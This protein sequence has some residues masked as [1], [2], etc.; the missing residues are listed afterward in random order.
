[1]D[2]T[3]YL[4]LKSRKR[5]TKTKLPRCNIPKD[6]ETFYNRDNISRCTA[7]KHKTRTSGKKDA[8]NVPDRH[9]SKLVQYLQKRRSVQFHKHF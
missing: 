7:G 1:M 5:K 3:K 6:I 4:G 9:I 8:D 2:V